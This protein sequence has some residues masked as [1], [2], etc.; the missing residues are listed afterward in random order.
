[1][2]FILEIRQV[3][4]LIISCLLL[5]TVI[6]GSAAERFA[7]APE[8][9][10][11]ADE[12]YGQG[13]GQRLR[14]WQELINNG[15]DGMDKEKIE[16]VNRFFNRMQFVSDADHWGREDYWA[17][18]VE[19]LAS[20]GG[21]CEDF[22]IAKYFTL[23]AMGIPENKLNLTYVKALQLNQHHMVMTYY[24]KP[25][26]EPLVLDNLV[27][28]ILP[29]SQRKDLLP[30]Y[31]FNGSALWLAKERGRGKLVGS[32]SRLSRWQEMLQ[33]MPEGIR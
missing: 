3:S 16:T 20:M 24:E 4:R 7:I 23:K 17:T 26:G 10:R 21:D 9:F 31:S 18:P 28:V 27:D 22:S 33:R 12:K 6:P 2:K 5:M 8:T 29:A 1:M 15:Q 19:F 11:Q 30:I 32:S 13:A 25:G 14:D